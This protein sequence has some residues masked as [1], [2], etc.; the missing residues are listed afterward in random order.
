MG[1]GGQADDAHVPVLFRETLENLQLEPGQT[2]VDCTF[3]RGGHSR[4]MLAHLGPEGRIVG[5]DRDP[6]AVAAGHALAA[7]DNRFPAPLRMFTLFD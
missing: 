1:I 6:E 2:V 7:N 4:G 5:L 3:G